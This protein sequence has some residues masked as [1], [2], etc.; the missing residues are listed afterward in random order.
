MVASSIIVTAGLPIA[1][2]S[3]PARM[4]RWN[5]TPSP[6]ALWPL[7]SWVNRPVMPGSIT[8][9]K[10]PAGARAVAVAGQQ[11]L[12]Y[13]VGHDDRRALEAHDAHVG[14]LRAG[15]PRPAHGRLHHL[16]QARRVY[17]DYLHRS[18]H[19]VP[20]LASCHY[21]GRVVGVFTV[22]SGASSA[23]IRSSSAWS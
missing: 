22:N 19:A 16:P 1:S 21:A 17:P 14:E 7:A 11:V 2:P 12:G 15:L 18:T 9:G 23:R 20:P 8:T 4:L 3:R 10:R 5:A 6:S 13:P